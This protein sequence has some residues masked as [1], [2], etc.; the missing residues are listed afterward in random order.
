VE[1]VRVILKT[2]GCFLAVPPSDE[3]V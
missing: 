1:E 3:D 2:A